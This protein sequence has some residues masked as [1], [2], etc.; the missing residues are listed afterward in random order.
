MPRNATVTSARKSAPTR[1]SAMAAWKIRSLLQKAPNG[2]QVLIQGI[3]NPPTR[4]YMLDKVEVKPP[5]GN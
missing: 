2:S 1:A 5:P 4:N 3:L